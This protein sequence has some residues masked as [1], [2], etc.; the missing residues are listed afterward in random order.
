[1][2]TT[3]RPELSENSKYFITRHRYYELKHFC[4]QYSYWRK[5][6]VILSGYSRNPEL[7]SHV[8]HSDFGDPTAR[9]AEEMAFY[10]CRMDTVKKAAFETDEVL[11]DYILKAVTEG[12]SYE[13]V[14]AKLEIPCGRETYY[15]L[16]RRFFWLLDKA[17]G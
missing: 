14:K 9:I 10:S 1:M 4:L 7:Y 8:K 11:G 5:Q 2:S 15:E 12:L 6:Y 17:R 3:I 16:Y 13:A